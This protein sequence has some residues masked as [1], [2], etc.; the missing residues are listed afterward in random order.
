MD[1]AGY[2]LVMLPVEQD[3]KD[4]VHT[5]AK[6]LSKKYGMPVTEVR[7]LQYKIISWLSDIHFLEYS[8]ASYY[9]FS[10]NL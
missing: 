6:H 10:H 2:S 5:V 3:I 1:E 9:F 7:F 4:A 8:S